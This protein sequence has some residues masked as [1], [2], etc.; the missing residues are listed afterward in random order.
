MQKRT[1]EEILIL[2]GDWERD[3]RNF[4]APLG[5]KS[6]ML[7]ITIIAVRDDA[8]PEPALLDDDQKWVCDVMARIKRESFRSYRILYMKFVLGYSQERIRGY[9]KMRKTRACE[10]IQLAIFYAE[11]VIKKEMPCKLLEI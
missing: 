10:E 5:Y 1:A 11:A 3:R 8:P 9:L 2:W 4:L 6:A 7:A